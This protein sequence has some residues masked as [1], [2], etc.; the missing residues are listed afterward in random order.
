MKSVKTV[1]VSAAVLI[2][3][4]TGVAYTQQLGTAPFPSILGAPGSLVVSISDDDVTAISAVAAG[5]ILTSQGVGVLPAWDDT[6][7]ISGSVQVGSTGTPVTQIRVYTVELTPS[8]V[9]A[10]ICAE[11]AFTVSGITNADKVFFNF[12]EQI[13]AEDSDKRPVGARSSGNDTLAVTFCNIGTEAGSPQ[14]G[15]FN[16]VAIRS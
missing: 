4:A 1:A 11:E 9:A 6:P 12:D 15:T 16:V 10:G 14:P 8:S 2:L 3:A 13:A 7:L 5:A